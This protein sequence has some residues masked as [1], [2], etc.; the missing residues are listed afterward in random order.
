MSDKVKL[1]SNNVRL[2]RK[3]GVS[4]KNAAKMMQQ[5]AAEMGADAVIDMHKGP[6]CS[7]R[8][9]AGMHY[10]GIAVKHLENGKKAKPLDNP[11][12]I[13]RLPIEDPK[14]PGEYLF[15]KNHTWENFPFADFPWVNR[16]VFKGYHVLPT[17]IIT[18]DKKSLK[19]IKEMSG[20]VLTSPNY[21]QER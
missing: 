3:T 16:A 21:T 7:W 13:F 11:F 5:V 14:K 20:L 2:S 15:V 12:V 17:N 10:S 8:W 9:D 18:D 4:K 1:R 6:G 19:E